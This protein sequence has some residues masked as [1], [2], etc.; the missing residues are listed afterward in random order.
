MKKSFIK[1][2]VALALVIVSV[3]SVSAVA[4]AA[5]SFSGKVNTSHG[6]TPGG[7][8]NYYSGYNSTASNS[9][10]ARKGSL[11]NGT[12]ITVTDVNAH[13]YSF[14]KNGTTYY[15]MRQYVNVNGREEEIRYGTTELNLGSSGRYVTT[16]QKDLKALG[17]D[18]K[19]VDGKFGD[20]TRKALYA[21][22]ADA[23]VK[24]DGRCGPATRRA[25]YDAIK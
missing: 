23:K 12:N 24:V 14:Q 5:A 4:F 10:L 2:L 11:S 13:W 22:Q 25:L 16:L 8:V 3:F 7:S 15:V 17:Y 6:A 18:P 9:G 19:G 21:F 20:D 1:R